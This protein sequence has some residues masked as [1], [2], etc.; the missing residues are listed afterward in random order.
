MNDRPLTGP[1]CTFIEG[2]SYYISLNQSYHRRPS[3][4]QP[5]L[6]ASRRTALSTVHSEHDRPLGRIHLIDGTN[7]DHPSNAISITPYG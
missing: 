7:I 4:S 3:V 6:S 1:T 5:E 2:R